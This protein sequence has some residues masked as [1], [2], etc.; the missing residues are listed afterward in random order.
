MSNKSS[1]VMEQARRQAKMQE[2]MAETFQ[3]ESKL[4]YERMN[5]KKFPTEKFSEDFKSLLEKAKGKL[6]PTTTEVPVKAFK[7]AFNQVHDVDV[8]QLSY[9]QFGVLSNSLEYLPFDM[10]YLTKE[11]YLCVIDEWVEYIDMYQDENNAIKKQS[12]ADV[13]KEMEMKLAAVAAQEGKQPL[14]AVK[15]EA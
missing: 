6:C 10:T 9:F 13:K 1:A 8:M 7:E 2:L 14:S 15:G 3:R 5:D 4:W 12:Q 11:Q